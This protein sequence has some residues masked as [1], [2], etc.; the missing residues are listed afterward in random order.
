MKPYKITTH[1]NPYIFRAYDLRGVMDQD[2][3]GDV[4]Y[5]LGRGTATLYQ[6]RQ[7]N[8]CPVGYDNRYHSEEYAAAYRKGLNDG[9]VG[10]IDLGYSLAQ[11]VYYSAYHF[12]T[13]GAAMV[14]AS[15]N[16]REFNGLKIN[17]DYSRT[18]I[19]SELQELADII[20]KEEFSVGKGKNREEDVYP[21]YKNEV[22]KRFHFKKRWSIVVDGCN[23]TAGLFYPDLYRSAGF[24]VLEKNTELDGNFP[25]GVPDPTDQRVLQRL[26]PEVLEKKADLGLA[27]DADGDRMA[28][29]DETGQV[30][31]MDTIVALFA[32]DVLKKNPHTPIVFNTYCS[33]QVVETI[34]NNGGKPIMW[35]TGHS[36]IKEKVKEAHAPFGG[37]LS[38][39]LFFAK[40][41]YSHDDGAYA[42]L[43]LIQIL[44]EE[45]QPL[46]SLVSKLPHYI[47]SPEIKLGVA[48][49]IKF[50]FIKNKIYPEFK[51]A[52]PRAHFTLLD[53]VRVDTTD[54][55]VAIRASQN[56]PYLGMKFEAK[57]QEQYENLK[58]R[59]K[60]ILL[61]YKEIDWVNGVNT[62]A[63][64]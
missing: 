47:G 38:G 2:L 55:M 48:D 49:D 31:W 4:Y 26:V 8:L 43:R 61:K 19:T 50:D 12:Q 25:L 44:E 23:S 52:W 45:G 20:K 60:K 62:E 33:K 11:I 56:G 41:F 36:F 35:L 22:L 3:N 37:E 58:K 10:T 27:Y 54:E 59:I 40:D 34:T 64:D 14:T 32:Q 39:H 42:G 1:L 9:G 6:R 30:L 46:S 63:L 53:G 13:K 29:V 15:H 17:I 7:I 51:T 57:T 28:V 5:T 18:T 24:K 16:S 21:A